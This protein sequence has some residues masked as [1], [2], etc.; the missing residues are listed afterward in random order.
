MLSDG[1]EASAPKR[2]PQ[3]LKFAVLVAG[4][5]LAAGIAFL[6]NQPATPLPA[7]SEVE[8]MQAVIDDPKLHEE[9]TVQV[10]RADWPTF[11]SAMLPAT[12]DDHPSK[13]VG[14]GDLHL[15]LK[16]GKTFYIELFD[17][18]G[19][20]IGA[21]AAGPTFETRTYYRGGNSQKLNQAISDLL[22]ASRDKHH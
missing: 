8:R 1:V 18:Q 9:V 17:L 14:T 20:K 15:K 11:Y 2:R 13:W 10:P 4:A 12:K 7:L 5:G 3:F 21:F 22:K 19:A 6:L 16:N